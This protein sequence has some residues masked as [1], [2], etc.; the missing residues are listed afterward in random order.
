[1]GKE[2]KNMLKKLIG[3]MLVVC[4]LFGMAACQPKADDN[5]DGNGGGIT[6]RQRDSQD[7]NL[8]DE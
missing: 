4:L 5:Q 7:P 1:M 8:F 3:L 2:V 6:E